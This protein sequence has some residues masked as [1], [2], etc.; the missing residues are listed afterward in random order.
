MQRRTVSSTSSARSVKPRE[1][2]RPT[3]LRSLCLLLLAR[4]SL[5]DLNSLFPPAPVKKPPG[6]L[7]SIAAAVQPRIPT[8]SPAPSQHRRTSS[9]STSSGSRRTL[10]S[11]GHR[12]RSSARART[13]SLAISRNTSSPFLPSFNP[14]SLPSLFSPTSATKRARKRTTSR[15]VSSRYM[16]GTPTRTRRRKLGTGRLF[17]RIDS[18]LRSCLSSTR[19]RLSDVLRLRRRSWAKRIRSS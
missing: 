12:K 1:S 4:S 11:Y 7:T 19:G 2:R 16:S 17:I 5:A 13:A 3:V 10:E 14:S 8:S 6:Q 18:F 9:S 15:S